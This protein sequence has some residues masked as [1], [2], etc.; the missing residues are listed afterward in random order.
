MVVKYTNLVLGSKAVRGLQRMPSRG[1]SWELWLAQYP[2]SVWLMAAIAVLCLGALALLYWLI[3][4]L[5]PLPEEP[6]K[7]A[8][9]EETKKTR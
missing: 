5:P 1:G 6:P 4:C 2:E 7:G 3:F 8:A 9:G